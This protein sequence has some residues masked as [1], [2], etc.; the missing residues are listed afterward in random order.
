MKG[1]G[2]VMRMKERQEIKVSELSK[3][4][5]KKDVGEGTRGGSRKIKCA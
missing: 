5:S 3:I 2:R 4:T 1:A